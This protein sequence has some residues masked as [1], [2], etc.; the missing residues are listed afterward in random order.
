MN[1]ALNHA[2]GAYRTANKAVAPTKAVTLLLD[3][4]VNAIIL[5]S[6]YLRRKEFE[7]A[8]E[9]IVHASKVLSGLRQNINM[10]AS[11]ELGQQFV[12]MYTQNIFALHSAYGKKDAIERFAT[13]A[14]GMLELRNAWAEIS[15]MQ[16]R[17]IDS[18][19][20]EIL[21]QKKE[22]AAKAG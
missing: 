8:F 22:A 14:S 13:V 11:P 9:R 16:Q 10:D 3:E 2:I 15:R 18:V 7:K 5:T 19:M 20:E 6:Y 17:S 4:V 12:D 21:D 1:Y